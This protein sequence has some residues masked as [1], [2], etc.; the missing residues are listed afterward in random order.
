M[1]LSNLEIRR[2]ADAFDRINTYSHFI[3]NN[4]YNSGLQKWKKSNQ[5]AIYYRRLMN[6]TKRISAIL[7]FKKMIKKS[8]RSTIREFFTQVK[9]HSLSKRGYR[10]KHAGL[11]LLKDV[12]NKIS[13]KR[14][15]GPFDTL[16]LKHTGHKTVTELIQK[17]EPVYSGSLFGRI[18]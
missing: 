15:E 5:D 1:K 16:A 12:M 6:A 10:K 7:H 14:M 8:N 18:N 4:L 17:S 3:L 2:T 11:E 9:A 13:R